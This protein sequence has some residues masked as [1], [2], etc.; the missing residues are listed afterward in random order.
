MLPPGSRGLSCPK[1]RNGNKLS[2]KHTYKIFITSIKKMDLFDVCWFSGPKWNILISKRRGWIGRSLCIQLNEQT[3]DTCKNKSWCHCSLFFNLPHHIVCN[4]TARD[5]NKDSLMF[6]VQSRSKCYQEIKTLFVGKRFFF[7]VV[8]SRWTTI[9][10]YIQ[11]LYFC[12]YCHSIKPT[13]MY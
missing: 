1:L 7:A 2:L 10:V 9:F 11:I 8:F 13:L 3:F 12:I 4:Q 6:A 5:G